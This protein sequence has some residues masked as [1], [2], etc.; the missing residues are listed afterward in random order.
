MSRESKILRITTGFL[1]TVDDEAAGGPVSGVG[2]A[3]YQG[4]LGA[5]VSL[6]A[7]QAAK[8]SDTSVATLFAGVYRYVR[9]KT[10]STISPARG[11]IAFWDTSVAGLTDS[12]VTPDLPTR[13]SRIAGIYLNAITK[14]AGNFGFIQ[15]EGI[16]NVQ[17]IG[18]YTKATPAAGDR[19]FVTTGAVMD[20]LADA[21]A[22]TSS[23]IVQAIG[24]AEETPTD[25]NI[26]RVLLDLAQ[27]P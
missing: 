19:C 25:G 16:A 10:G 12:V 17:G 9:T 14:T 24:L 7:A 26:S 1:N 21:T 11:L 6:T 13:P 15:T 22:I 23:N 20:V 2:E 8:R 18:T 3:Q 5:W 27:L 4:Q